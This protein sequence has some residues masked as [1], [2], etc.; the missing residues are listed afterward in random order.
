MKLPRMALYQP[1]SDLVGSVAG[2]MILCGIILGVQDW[3]D[4]PAFLSSG[5]GDG[6]WDL[7]GGITVVLRQWQEM[8]L[9]GRPW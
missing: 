9:P 4:D 8:I 2:C 7:G 6:I 5:R 1:Y 3:T